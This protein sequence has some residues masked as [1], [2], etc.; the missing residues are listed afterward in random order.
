MDSDYAE[1]KD[2]MESE[3]ATPSLLL[4]LIA[5]LNHNLIKLKRLVINSPIE[6][7]DNLTSA[8]KDQRVRRANFDS[9]ATAWHKKHDV[10]VQDIKIVLSVP[11]TLRSKCSRSTT[12]SIKIAQAIAKQEVA[13]LKL[14]HL[15]EQQE[16]KCEVAKCKMRL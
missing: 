16:L 14:L 13:R 1:I 6:I 15:E 5:K 4:P 7:K 3:E 10:P 8:F 2:L 11:G 12:S 9:V